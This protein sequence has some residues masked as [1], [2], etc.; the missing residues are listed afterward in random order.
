MTYKQ[1]NARTSALSKVW[2]RRAFLLAA[3]PCVIMSCE[4]G[5]A[6]QHKPTGT[7]TDPVPLCERHGQVC[8]LDKSQLGVCVAAQSPEAKEKCEGRFPCLLCAPQH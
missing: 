2:V 6:K 5:P 4:S 8:R 3:I 1:I 7:P